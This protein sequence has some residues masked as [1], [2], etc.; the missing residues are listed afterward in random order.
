MGLLV[1]RPEKHTVN[2]TN[3]ALAKIVQHIRNNNPD[4]IAVEPKYTY[5]G[6]EMGAIGDLGVEEIARVLSQNTSILKLDLGQNRI[7]NKGI[8]AMC[9]ALQ[10]N[11]QITELDL[12]VNDI[13][14][15]GAVSLSWMLTKNPSL[16]VLNLRANKIGDAGAESF[17]HAVKPVIR[18]GAPDKDCSLTYLDLA[19]NDI[20]DLGGVVFSAGLA[21]NRKLDVLNMGWN[22]VGNATAGGLGEWAPSTQIASD[23]YKY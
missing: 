23:L 11:K 10:D 7:T 20:G 12:H 2:I 1:D 13:G 21:N 15:A 16:T 3:R 8:A 19:S 17:V 6:Q 4:V 5:Q 14:Y 9:E 18:H 22:H